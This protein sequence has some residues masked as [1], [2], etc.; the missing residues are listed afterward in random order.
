MNKILISSSTFGEYSSEPIDMLKKAGLE[1]VLNPYKRRLKPEEVVDLAED[2][3]GIIAGVEDLDGHTLSQL[4]KLQVISRVGIGLE[5]IELEA[6]EKLGITIK[7]T[8]DAPTQAV[9]EMAIGLI[10][11]LL[12]NISLEDRLMHAG[13]WEKKIGG[14]LSGKTIGIIGIGRIGKR[15]AE[16]LQGM[17]VKTVAC[18]LAPDAAWAEKHGV[19]L[20]SLDALLRSS[21]I[22]TIHVSHRGVLL[23]DKELRIMKKGSCIVNLCRG[24]IVEEEALYNALK[25]SRLAGAALDVFSDEPY[26]GP[27]A[28][29]DNVILTPHIGSYAKESRIV[30]ETEA[31]RNLLEVLNN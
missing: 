10:L 20:V 6:A 30:M 19:G 29:L 26:S 4:K 16:L 8:P 15:V 18:D 31:A 12:R 27:L 14:L 11:N 23:R 5:N 13:K 9:A 21:D 3:V 7:N 28:T 2:C 22:V 25:D 17:N 1:V 24:N